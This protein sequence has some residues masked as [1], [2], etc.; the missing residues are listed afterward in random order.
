MF[1]ITFNLD[2]E[3]EMMDK[4]DLSKEELSAKENNFEKWVLDLMRTLATNPYSKV[5]FYRYRTARVLDAIFDADRDSMSPLE[6]ILAI[7]AD[8]NLDNHT[9]YEVYDGYQTFYIWCTDSL[10]RVGKT[11]EKEE[12]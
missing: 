6:Y 12:W 5:T 1:R 4:E 10:F 11:I 7:K 3:W 2:W 9:V 8:V